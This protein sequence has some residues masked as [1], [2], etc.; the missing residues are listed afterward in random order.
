MERETVINGLKCCSNSDG[1][2]CLDCPFRLC[3]NCI[4]TICVDALAL[5]KEQAK[6]I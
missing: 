6:K 2:E 3:N 1:L 5:L 4:E